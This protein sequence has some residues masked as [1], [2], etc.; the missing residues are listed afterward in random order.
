[1]ASRYDIV[2]WA[3]S[4]QQGGTELA[5]LL[6]LGLLKVSSIFEKQP[7]IVIVTPYKERV[8]EF[9]RDENVTCPDVITSPLLLRLEKMRDGTV[10]PDATAKLLQEEFMKDNFAPLEARIGYCLYLILDHIKDNTLIISCGEPIALEVARRANRK[11]IIVSDHLLTF[12]LR[13]VLEHGGLIREDANMA[14][15]MTRFEGFDR[16]ALEAYL[17]PIEFGS[18]EYGDYLA[19]GGRPCIPIRGLFYEPIDHAEL[20]QCPPYVELVRSVQANTPSNSDM[21]I[22]SVFGG[23]GVVWDEIFLQL[24]EQARKPEFAQWGFALLLRDFDETGKVV[25]GKWRLYVPAPGKTTEVPLGD[26]GKLMY[27]YS[28]CS[29]V[30]ARGGLAAQQ[31]VATMLSDLKRV[32]QM[33][34]VEEPGHPQIESER[35][36]LYR[37]GLIYT[38]TLRSF[39]QNPFPLI[40]G[41]LAQQGGERNHA[42]VRYGRNAM[43]ALCES[44]IEGYF[45]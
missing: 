11:S 2:I 9:F 3:H 17:S 36:Y 37:L 21:P 22:V 30:V 43:Q 10:D 32:P 31:V 39:R 15:L 38:R 41:F 28:A 35:L 20:Q 14:R 23:G 5:C 25:R 7:S 6:A 24:H 16:S 29:L 42:R 18:P 19:Q 44:I 45:S 12:T 33:L 1:M 13:R 27:W 40:A 4:D 8:D 26:P 34:F